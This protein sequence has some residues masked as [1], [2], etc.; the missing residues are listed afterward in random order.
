[1]KDSNPLLEQVAQK[2]AK[3]QT[4]LATEAGHLNSNSN[5]ASSQTGNKVLSVSQSAVQQIGDENV[6]FIP[7]GEEFEEKDI[8]V[9]REFSEFVE[10]KSGLHQGE[11]VVSNGSFALKSEMQKGAFGDGHNH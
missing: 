9:G 11:V 7:K 2:I 5:N 10:I 6:V 3:S 1:M 8:V 4:N